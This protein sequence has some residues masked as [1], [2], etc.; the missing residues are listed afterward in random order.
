MILMKAG[1]HFTKYTLEAVGR[2]HS[3]LET[4]SLN[5]W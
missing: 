4:Y 1:S 2:S 5:G 3:D